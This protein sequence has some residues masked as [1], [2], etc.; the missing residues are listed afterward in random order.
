VGYLP[1]TVAVVYLG[2]KARTFSTSD[3]LV[4]VAVAVLVGLLAAQWILHYRR[5]QRKLPP[6]RP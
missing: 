1:L 4:W 6:G 3:P 5:T 2:A